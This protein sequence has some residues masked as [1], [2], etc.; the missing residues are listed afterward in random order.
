MCVCVCVCECV[1]G[2]SV[3]VC[4]VMCLHSTK[5]HMQDFDLCV[6]CYETTKHEHPMERLG[7]GVMDPEDQESA[8]EQNPQV[9]VPLL[10]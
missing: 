6:S 7:L 1:S 5:F 8:S 3:C 9:G 2:D 4:N 10:P